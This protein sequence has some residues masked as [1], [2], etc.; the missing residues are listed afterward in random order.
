MEVKCPVC[1]SATNQVKQLSQAFIVENLEK[2]YSSKVDRKILDTDYF[3]HQCKGCTLEFAYPLIQGNDAFYSWI[4]TRTTYYPHLRSEYL[5]VIDHINS[6]PTGKKVKVLDIGCGSGL[7]M[8]LVKEKCPNAEIDG[9]ETT[10]ESVAACVDAGLN[11]YHSYLDEYVELCRQKELAY[12]VI[13]AFHV[14][15]H[16]EDPKGFV[17]TAA[18]LLAAGGALF[19]STP[20]SPMSFETDW[21]D[22]LNHPPHHM[23]RWTIKAYETLA[24][25]CQLQVKVWLEDAVKPLSRAFTTWRLV[26]EMKQSSKTKIAASIVASPLAFAK[27]LQNQKQRQQV[28]DKYLPDVILV[29]LY[30]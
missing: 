16:V 9:L 19:I 8:K 13:V 17:S 20:L 18:S 11:A 21:Y 3:I 24:A 4:T 15:E 6:L 14:L 26:K 1:A 25:K 27:V 2:Y 30:K 22:P 28:D 23:T 12:D 10:P 5:Q 29:Q 7:F